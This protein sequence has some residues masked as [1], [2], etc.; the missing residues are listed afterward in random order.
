MSTLDDLR[1]TLDERAGALTDDGL[2]DRAGAV[3]GRVSRI[4][5]RRAAIGVAAVVLAIGAGVGLRTV[6]LGRP[7]AIAPAGPRP[8]LTGPVLGVD[9]PS[10]LD[11][12]GFPYRR[13]DVREIDEAAQPLG[14]GR[15]AQAVVLV[16]SG[17]AGGGIAT[18]YVD[19]VAVARVDAAHPVAPAYPI[20]AGD[21]RLSVRLADAGTDARTALAVFRSDEL[22]PGVAAPDGSA[23]FRREVAGQ[24]LVGAAWSIGDQAPPVVRV[25]DGL[26]AGSTLRTY[27][28][29][30]AA[31][32]GLATRTDRGPL[33]SEFGCSDE[34]R[35][36]VSSSTYGQS[37]EAGA[38]TARPFAIRG[39]RDEE[40]AP[41]TDVPSDLLV[42]VAVYAP[43]PSSGEELL[44]TAVPE[45][46]EQGGRTWR[47]SHTVPELA[48]PVSQAVGQPG[49]GD[50]LVMAYSGRGTAGVRWTDARGDQGGGYYQTTNDT[51]STGVQD[52]G[53][54]LGGTGPYVLRQ[55]P[56]I[57]DE[58]PARTALAVYEPLD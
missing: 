19:D 3:R 17:L 38:V 49:D 40:E 8:E 58:R 5:R 55:A 27:C 53:V 47:L 28:R 39:S 35:D 56:P 54:L 25:P 14:G 2:A 22:A 30:S 36:A 57:E 51:D 24:R 23:V 11:V 42:G 21:A 7:D 45:Y 52:V 31:D 50:R 12:L 4:R 10:S 33:G 16:G 18:L 44:G 26:P 43:M 46:V 34:G 37:A 20:D 1:R 13:V 15:S 48:G 41:L 29:T 9:V 32:V 6:D